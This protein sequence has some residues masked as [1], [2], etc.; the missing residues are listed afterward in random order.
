MELWFN[1][2]YEKDN[3]I[4]NSKI[5]IELIALTVFA[6]LILSLNIQL[7]YLVS[8]SILGPG[9]FSYFNVF[10]RRKGM[11]SE[12]THWSMV[13]SFAIAYLLK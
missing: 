7:K 12:I 13:V 10:I 9:M 1:D 5:I 11:K 2:S 6:L 8:L 4:S 3:S